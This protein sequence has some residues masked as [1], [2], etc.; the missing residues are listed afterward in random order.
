MVACKILQQILLLEMR[1][2]RSYLKKEV[3]Y[4]NYHKDLKVIDFFHIKEEQQNT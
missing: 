2:Y 4:N 1:E 3:F